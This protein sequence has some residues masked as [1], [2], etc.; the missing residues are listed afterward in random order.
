MMDRDGR[1]RFEAIQEATWAMEEP[2]LSRAQV[3]A[4]INH[5]RYIFLWGT[6]LKDKNINVN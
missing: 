6:N 1:T 3:T 4:A 5:D 2:P